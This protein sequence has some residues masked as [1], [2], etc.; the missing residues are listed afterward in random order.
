LPGLSSGPPAG[1]AVFINDPELRRRIR[2]AGGFC[3]PHSFQFLGYHDGFAGSIL[4]RDL[5]NA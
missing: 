2:S 3:S 1:G 5:L 4:Y